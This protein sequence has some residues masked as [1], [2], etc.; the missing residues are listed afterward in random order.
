MKQ[1]L[2]PVAVILFA[3][4]SIGVQPSAAQS[5]PDASGSGQPW[6]HRQGGS[7]GPGVSARASSGAGFRAQPA[8]AAPGAITDTG[9]ASRLGATVGMPSGAL[10]PGVGNINNPGMQPMPGIQP[11]I[12]N[13]PGHRNINFPGGTPDLYR[14]VPQPS[15]GGPWKDGWLDGTPHKRGGRPV[16]IY[17]GVP[18]YIPYFVYA[19]ESAPASSSSASQYGAA[20]SEPASPPA[21]REPATQPLTLL[22]FKDGTVVIAKAYWLEGDWLY[23]ETTSGQRLSGPLDRLDIALTQQLNRERNVRFVLESR[24]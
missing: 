7:P 20:S 18:Y 16:V 23:Y 5:G 12:P 17:Y 9:F 21:D 6:M 3:F 22:A 8:P 14:R 13:P 11:L 15:H 19:L 1:I 10:P 2:P 24:P 4:L